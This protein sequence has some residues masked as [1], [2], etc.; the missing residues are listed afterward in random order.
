MLVNLNRAAEPFISLVH[1][2]ILYRFRYSGVA[3][4]STRAVM[5]LLRSL[6]D[7]VPLVNQATS[8]CIAVAPKSLRFYYQILSSS[9]SEAK[10][11]TV[12]V[13][14]STVDI[15]IIPNEFVFADFDNWLRSRL[16]LNNGDR[17]LYLNADNSKGFVALTFRNIVC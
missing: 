12:R 14:G 8:R 10:L 17:L 3:G 9:M 5:L 11:I 7:V 4:Y 2:V 1:H 15:K 6:V 16:G 13:E